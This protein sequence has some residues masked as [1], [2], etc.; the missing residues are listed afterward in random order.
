MT[1]SDP[2]P[3]PPHPRPSGIEE[4]PPHPPFRP[5]GPRPVDAEYGYWDGV[6]HV[7]SSRAGLEERMRKG[8]RTPLVWTPETGGMAPPWRVPYLFEAFRRKGEARA[9]NLAV[10]SALLALGFAVRWLRSGE[11]DPTTLMLGFLFLALAARGAAD[12]RRWRTLTVERIAAELRSAGVRPARR[13]RAVYTQALCGVLVAAGLTQLFALEGSILAAGIIKD[14]VRAGEWWRLLTGALLHG[15]EL[16]FLFNFL[17]LLALGRLVE[18]YAHRAFVPLVFLLSAGVASVASLVFL[19]YENSVGA[20]GGL[21]G[22]FGFLAVLGWRRRRLMPEGFG[23]AIAMDVGL[24]AV[25]GIVGYQFVDNAAHGG[26]L[27]AGA[28]LG[29]LFVPTGGETAYW[30]PP[31]A[32]RMAGDAALALLIAVVIATVLLVVLRAYG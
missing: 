10:G 20:S 29:L 14:A 28:L 15:S 18:A 17:A 11:L 25:I 2:R 23:R 24:V 9:R 26:G 3:E 30:T 12:W 21:M 8:E 32:L 22:L 4:N 7:P 16:H 19:P 5:G 13:G 31:R 27:L 6:R 1:D